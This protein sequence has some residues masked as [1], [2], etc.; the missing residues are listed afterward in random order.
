MQNSGVFFKVLWVPSLCTSWT[1]FSQAQ[2]VCV[3][4]CVSPFIS[5][6]LSLW[7]DFFYEH[8]II[9]TFALIIFSSDISSLCLIALS[10]SLSWQIYILSPFICH[11]SISF[12]LPRQI[13]ISVTS[14]HP[15]WQ[16]FCL[17]SRVRQV[18][19]LRFL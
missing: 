17:S 18:K 5:I 8:F 4:V 2:C 9:L 16:H 1:P 3:C 12:H 19:M 10:P 14:S 6:Y 13:Y 15:L 11:V 7:A